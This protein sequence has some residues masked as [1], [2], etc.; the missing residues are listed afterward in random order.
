MNIDLTTIEG[1]S[2]A[3]SL[4]LHVPDEAA[5]VQSPRGT[6]T[7]VL[8]MLLPRLNQ[9]RGRHWS[10]EAKAKKDLVQWLRVCALEQSVPTAQGPRFVF[11]DVKLGPR[12]KK[13]DADA[14]D[15]ILLDALVSAGLLLDDSDRGLIGRVGIAFERGPVSETRITLTDHPLTESE[16]NPLQT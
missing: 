2:A 4:G 8:P 7:L 14:Y 15:K 3:R 9:V 1:R 11:V 10:A 12:R 16:A 6:H 13:P 5:P